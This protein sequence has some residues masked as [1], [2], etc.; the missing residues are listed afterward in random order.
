[1]Q[2]KDSKVKSKE[3]KSGKSRKFNVLEQGMNLAYEGTESLSVWLDH[4]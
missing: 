4:D 3:N 1:M 2:E